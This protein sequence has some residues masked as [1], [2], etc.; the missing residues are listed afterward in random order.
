MHNCKGYNNIVNSISM[1]T[2]K[3]FSILILILIPSICYSHGGHH[4]SA[5]SN[6]SHVKIYPDHIE[7]KFTLEAPISDI[8]SNNIRVRDIKNNID[9]FINNKETGWLTDPKFRSRV[10][11]T[12]HSSFRYE[13]K[14]IALLPEVKTGKK[15]SLKIINKNFEN[16]KST[17]Q[18][19]ISTQKG[20]EIKNS[21]IPKNMTWNYNAE[22]REIN[23]EFVLK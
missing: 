4:F 8:T 19:D 21:N 17:F 22:Y 23:V 12:S 2:I 14:L 5:I 15:Y 20:I 9:L 3:L 1:K 16:K 13:L 11:K 10:E 6:K 7:L 18:I